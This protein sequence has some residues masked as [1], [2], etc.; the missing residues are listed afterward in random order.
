MAARANLAVIG[1]RHL[2]KQQGGPAKYRGGGSIAYIGLARSALMVGIDPEDEASRILASSK[3]NLSTRPR[4]LRFAI[5]ELDNKQP[6]IEWKG[7]SDITADQLCALPE[8]ADTPKARQEARD[9]LF[10]QLAKGERYADELYQEGEKQ[11]IS[12][13]TLRRVKAAEGIVDRRAGKRWLWRLPPQQ[14]AGP[15]VEGGR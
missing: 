7:E 3:G 14:T 2:N 1:V 8:Q 10:K 4:S 6:R 13:R 15:A 9:F 11:S 5:I 12:E